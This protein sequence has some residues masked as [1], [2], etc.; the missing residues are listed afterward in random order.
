MGAG[1]R[2]HREFKAGELRAYS[3]NVGVNGASADILSFDIP[4][5]ATSA[6]IQHLAWVSA[7]Y[8]DVYAVSATEVSVYLT[9]IDCHNGASNSTFG[10][11]HSG[12]RVQVIAC[13]LDSFPGGRI[14][15]RCRKGIFHF[16]SLGFHASVLPCDATSFVHSD[17]IYVYIYMAALLVCQ[18]RA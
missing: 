4:A 12:I 17:N 8:H 5:G 11:V 16:M 7:G 15:I 10:A 14:E 6:V 3:S 18:L 1:I 2:G 13:D 9:R